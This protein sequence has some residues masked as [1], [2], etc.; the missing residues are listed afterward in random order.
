VL[1]LV[2]HLHHHLLVV[3]LAA[4]VLLLLKIIIK[5]FKNSSQVFFLPIMNVI[6][7]SFIKMEKSTR[8]VRKSKKQ[9]SAISRKFN[10]NFN[11]KKDIQNG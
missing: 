3:R 4:A 5:K 7:H 6:T 9:V 11:R 8:V 1:R 10:F 2:P